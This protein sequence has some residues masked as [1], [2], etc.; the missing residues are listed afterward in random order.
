TDDL[1]FWGTCFQVEQVLAG[2]GSDGLSEEPINMTFALD[3]QFR[4][5]E[6]QTEL[7]KAYEMSSKGKFR[8]GHPVDDEARFFAELTGEPSAHIYYLYCHGYAPAKGNSLSREG[9]HLIRDKIRQK[10]S[11]AAHDG[12]ETLLELTNKMNDDP[13]IFIGN[14]EIREAKLR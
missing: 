7:F 12:L 11:E 10:T 6:S 8:V 1:Q 4:N 3:R 5:A 13:W 9:V 14:S 2:P